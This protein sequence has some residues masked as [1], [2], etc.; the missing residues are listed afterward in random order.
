MFLLCCEMFLTHQHANIYTTHLRMHIV[1]VHVC[2]CMCLCVSMGSL[3]RALIN[4]ASMSPAHK[5][6]GQWS[7][8]FDNKRVSRLI[9]IESAQ[10]HSNAQRSARAH[11]SN[12]HTHTRIHN[13]VRIHVRRIARIA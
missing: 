3:A 8:L 1:Y 11:H 2:V 6:I 13:S 10:L 9:H 12:K 7:V 4:I 5:S